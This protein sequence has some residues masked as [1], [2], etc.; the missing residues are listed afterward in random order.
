LAIIG[1]AQPGWEGCLKTGLLSCCSLHDDIQAPSKHPSF[2]LLPLFV[3]EAVSCRLALQL[4][5]VVHPANTPD[6]ASFCPSTAVM[7]F[8]HDRVC[9]MSEGCRFQGLV[10]RCCR[11]AVACCQPAGARCVMSQQLRQRVHLSLTQ[12]HLVGHNMLLKR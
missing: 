3:Q 1:A 7:I 2:P 9:G 4:C 10:P 11:S 8:S 6:W 12:A 5:T